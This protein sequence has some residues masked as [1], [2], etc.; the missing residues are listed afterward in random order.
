MN[1]KK[2]DDKVIMLTLVSKWCDIC[3]Q[4]INTLKKNSIKRIIE[5]NFHLIIID[6]DEKPYLWNRFNFGGLPSIVFLSPNNE[7]LYGYSGFS[8]EKMMRKIL[9]MVLSGNTEKYS[10][11]LLS[12]EEPP[13]KDIDNSIIYKIVSAIETNFDWLYGGFIEDYKYIH[14]WEHIFLLNLF[15]ETGV[16][17]YSL[18]IQKTLDQLADSKM[19]NL[20]VGGFYRY[21]GNMNWS[22]PNKKI[23]IETNSDLLF[24]YASAYR[25]FRKAVYGHIS[26]E[27]E[28]F[29]NK[30]LFNRD[31]GLFI[32]GIYDDKIYDD[33][34]FLSLN[35]YVAET[36]LNTYKLGGNKKSVEKALKILE[37]IS[38]K[39]DIRHYLDVES[40]EYYLSDIVFMLRALL[41][42][43]EVTGNESWIEEWRRW[44]KT[45]E[46][47]FLN[48]NGAYN[49]VPT[50][51]RLFAG[52]IK[53]AP[54]EEN[55]LL[56]E[57]MIRYS[58]LFEDECYRNKAYKILKYYSGL[59]EKY[60]FNI[61]EYA[62]SCLLYFKEPS[63][64]YIYKYRKLKNK[65]RN[66]LLPNSL[67]RW[68]NKGQPNYII[69][70]EDKIIKFKLPK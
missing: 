20:S 45:I 61:G 55:S 34:Y 39:K 15:L 30:K 24:L 9:E 4:H 57:N 16:K 47:K 1:G 12:E 60:G 54:L 5:K 6:I 2:S 64:L 17:G 25:V 8:N 32:R 44:A 70:K 48:I 18:M 58:Y 13:Q 51:I 59:Y 11:Q 41:A 40:T 38:S 68:I 22:N 49:D 69:K 7:I 35:M 56:A 19:R 66:I 3:K 27:L 36:L 37:K 14:S 21:A 31:M 53:R 50:D 63:I 46:K 62:N 42:A 23:L 33:R 65:I 29:I 28:K 67:I 43:Y 26:E 52:E 10:I